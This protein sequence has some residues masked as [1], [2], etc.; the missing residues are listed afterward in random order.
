MPVNTFAIRRS[1]APCLFPRKPPDY[2]RGSVRAAQVGGSGTIR[3]SS[4]IRNN[5]GHTLEAQTIGAPPE[6]WTDVIRLGVPHSGQA[7]TATK[8]GA[9]DSRKCAKSSRK[10]ISPG[11]ISESD[12]RLDKC[13]SEGIW[14]ARLELGFPRTLSRAATVPDFPSLLVCLANALTTFPRARSLAKG[15]LGNIVR[16]FD[17]G[18]LNYRRCALS[19]FLALFPSCHGKA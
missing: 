8:L 7:S 9:N 18:D 5:P 11:A 2:A 16:L 17:P 6:Y 19:P 14:L 1:L 10:T 4:R 3:D 13:N 15:G 12:A